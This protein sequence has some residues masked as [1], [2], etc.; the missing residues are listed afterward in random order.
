[1]SLVTLIVALALVGFLLW[2]VNACVPM[3]PVIKRIINIVVLVAI[4]LWLLSVF[5]ILGD[6]R[7][8]RVP[9]V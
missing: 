7:A 3:D 5:G 2:V 6:L 4:C 1:M 9:H 8:V